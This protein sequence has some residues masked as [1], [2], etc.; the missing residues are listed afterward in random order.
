V[1][2][3]TKRKRSNGDIAYMA[4]IQLKKDGAIIHRECKTFDRLALAKV[5]VAKRELELL[6]E[7]KRD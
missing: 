5:W 4:N 2:T 1:A 7:S 3:I 6:V